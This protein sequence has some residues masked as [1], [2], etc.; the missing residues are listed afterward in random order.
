[1]KLNQFILPAFLILTFNS[2]NAQSGFDTH[3]D[4]LLFQIDQ[5]YKL[6]LIVFQ[7][8]STQADIDDI[9][10]LFTEDFTYVHPN[11]GGVYTREVLYNGYLRNQNNGG[12]DGSVIDIKVESKI[13]GLNAV[14][15]SKRFVTKEKG[16]IVEGEAQM[17]LFEFRDGKICRIYEYW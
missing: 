7:E 11:Y 2:A 15:V 14:A 16:Q 12:Y 13:T 8:N 5:Y 1:M 6:N 4:S 9:F 17:A 3:K 10:E